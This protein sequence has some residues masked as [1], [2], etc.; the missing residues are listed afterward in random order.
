MGN[1][2]PKPRIFEL[3]VKYEEDFESGPGHTWTVKDM[4]EANEAL[5]QLRKLHFIAWAAL[6]EKEIGRGT[7]ATFYLNPRSAYYSVMRAKYKEMTGREYEETG[8]AN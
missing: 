4:D 3:F 2:A 5:H 7:G 1:L 8:N 6:L